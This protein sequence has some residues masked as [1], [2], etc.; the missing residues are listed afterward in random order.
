MCVAGATQ[1][2]QLFSTGNAVRRLV[3]LR[4]GDRMDRAKHLWPI[5]FEAFARRLRAKER[6]WKFVSHERKY[7]KNVHDTKVNCGNHE[8][9]RK[10]L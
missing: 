5:E 10:S 2:K 8:I 7:P 9:R 6:A 3:A 1:P 4:C